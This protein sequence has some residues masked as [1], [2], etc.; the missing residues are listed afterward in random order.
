MLQRIFRHLQKRQSLLTTWQINPET[1][2]RMVYHS[3]L[4][5]FHTEMKNFS[6]SLTEDETLNPE[7]DLFFYA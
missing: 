2:K 5:S 4:G 7:L 1:G 6:V 3:T